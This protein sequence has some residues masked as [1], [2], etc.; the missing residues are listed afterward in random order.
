TRPAR[1]RP[2]GPDDEATP[3]G[4]ARASSVTPARAAGRVDGA[5]HLPG[6]AA[7]RGA[8]GLRALIAQYHP[9]KVAHLAPEFHELAERRT[10]EILDAWEAIERAWSGEG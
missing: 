2:T 7:G 9:D 6:H 3:P 8:Q 10:R 5:G 1:L 4:H